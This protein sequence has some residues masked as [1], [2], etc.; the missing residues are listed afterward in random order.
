MPGH[1]NPAEYLITIRYIE[2]LRDMTKGNN[3]KVIF[4][5]VETSSMLSSVGALKEMFAET[6][7][8]TRTNKG[9]SSQMPPP[10][11]QLPT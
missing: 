9:N 11:R 6:G 10:P 5:P 2:S 7:E 4:M 1:G 3:S 8:T